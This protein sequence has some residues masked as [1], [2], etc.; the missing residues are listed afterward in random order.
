MVS[1]IFLR[2]EMNSLF[3]IL[4]LVLLP[5]SVKA[6][7]LLLVDAEIPESYQIL[8]AGDSVLVETQIILVGKNQTD[9][10]TDVVIEYVVKD[11]DNKIITQLSETKGGLVRIQT[12]KELHLPSD[13]SLGTYSIS[14]RAS[15][16][17]VLGE[18]SASFKVAKPESNYNLTLSSANN[19]LKFILVGMAVLLAL[20][21]YQFWK[22]GKFYHRKR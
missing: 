12:V 2:R 9:T 17:E 20:S 10:L 1:K 19:L 22:I 14:I 8:A 18:T 5:I 4:L 3:L 21:M 6:E 16:K 15:Y 11:K 7:N 13:L